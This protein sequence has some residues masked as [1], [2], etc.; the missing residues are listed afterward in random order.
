VKILRPTVPF[1]PA[2]ADG[3]FPMLNWKVQKTT[4]K[5]KFSLFLF[6]FQKKKQK[7]TSHQK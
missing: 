7:S 2:G 1:F 5:S 6:G 4:T 3:A